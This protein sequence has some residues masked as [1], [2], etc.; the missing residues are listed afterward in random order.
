MEFSPQIDVAGAAA[1]L[2]CGSSKSATIY[3]SIHSVVATQNHL[4]PTNFSHLE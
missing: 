4:G 2:D 3:L 1:E